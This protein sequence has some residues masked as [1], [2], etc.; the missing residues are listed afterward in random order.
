M[1]NELRTQ[2]KSHDQK[3]ITYAGDILE[4]RSHKFT[5]PERPFTP[6]TNKTNHQ[7]RLKGSK[8]YNPPPKKKLNKTHDIDYDVDETLIKTSQSKNNKTLQRSMKVS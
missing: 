8:C 1:T 6:R 3:R 5:E 2:L 4:K 7:S